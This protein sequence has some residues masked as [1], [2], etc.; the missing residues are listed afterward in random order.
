[1]PIRLDIL[2]HFVYFLFNLVIDAKNVFTFSYNGSTDTAPNKI[3]KIIILSCASG[4][5]VQSRQ[6]LLLT[7][8]HAFLNF[9]LGKKHLRE[10]RHEL[11]QESR[12]LD[13]CAMN[14]NIFICGFR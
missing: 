14:V 11:L 12:G 3:G 7:A 2:S 4:K 5:A 13:K 6:A 8:L 10:I 1:M 9:V